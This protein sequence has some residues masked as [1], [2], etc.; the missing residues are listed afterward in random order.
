MRTIENF[1]LIDQAEDSWSLAEAR[2]RGAV[3]L[4]LYRGDW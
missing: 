2:K 4:V 3:V 1:T